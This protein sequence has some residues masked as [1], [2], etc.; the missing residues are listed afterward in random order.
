MLP[1]VLPVCP[2]LLYC[3]SSGQ[4]P[5]QHTKVQAPSQHLS[6]FKIQVLTAPSKRKQKFYAKNIENSGVLI[7]NFFFLNTKNALHEGYT[8]LIHAQLNQAM[9]QSAADSTPCLEELCFKAF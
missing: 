7:S 1:F 3:T 4:R 9:L 2:D 8:V 5:P 6:I